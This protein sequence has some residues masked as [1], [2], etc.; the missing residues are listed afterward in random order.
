MAEAAATGI[1]SHWR[2]WIPPA[3]CF[4]TSP[5]M[6]RREYGC[7]RAVEGEDRREV[8]SPNRRAV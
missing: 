1:R 8:S 3:T 2:S 6:G 7:D 4:R 5:Q